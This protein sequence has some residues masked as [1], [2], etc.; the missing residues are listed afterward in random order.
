MGECSFVLASALVAAG[1]IGG[2][3]YLASIAAVT[4]SIAVSTVLIRRVPVHD[5]GVASAA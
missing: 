4:I 2:E 3:D 5:A 1:A